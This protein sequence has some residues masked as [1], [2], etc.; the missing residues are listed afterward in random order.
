M[1]EFANEAGFR[2]AAQK[3]DHGQVILLDSKGKTWSSE[4]LATKLE[5]AR[6]N[7]VRNL[8]LACG[9]PDGWSGEVRGIGSAT[10]SLGR[11]TLPHHLAQLIAA[12]Q[13]YR[14]LTILANHPYHAG[15]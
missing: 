13:I 7:G 10:F 4:E 1:R 9:P 15:H 12:E 5:T 11:I 8:V 2:T 14:S 3:L 6:D